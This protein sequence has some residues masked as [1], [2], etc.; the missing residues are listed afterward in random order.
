MGRTTIQIGDR[1]ERLVVT[2]EAE[3]YLDSAG[4]KRRRKTCLCDCGNEKI[5]ADTCLR[6]GNVRSCGCLQRQWTKSGNAQRK[7]DEQLAIPD[8]DDCVMWTGATTKGYGKRTVAHRQGTDYVHRIA[9][10]QTYGPIPDGLDILHRCDNP[11]CYNPR[12]LFL[13]THRDNM[14]DMV[15]KERG[16]FKIP[17]RE[18][19]KI[20]LRLQNGERGVDLAK[21]FSVTKANITRIKRAARG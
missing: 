18:R 15:E 16:V 1:F 10:R 3:P 4:Y 17:L 21:E 12:H 6:S 14:V 20:P 19:R 13:G 11:P 9:W 7:Y 8:T 5:V 2:G